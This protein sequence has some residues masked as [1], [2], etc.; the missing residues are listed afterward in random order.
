LPERPGLGHRVRRG[1]AHRSHF[2]PAQRRDHARVGRSNGVSWGGPRLETTGWARGREPG[3]PAEREGVANEVP[4]ATDGRVR[5]DHEVGPAE[6]LLHLLGA[7]L[8][9]VL[10]P[11]EPAEIV[12]VGGNGVSAACGPPGRAKLVARYHVVNWGSVAG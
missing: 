4:V 8:H 10:R 7:L 6:L 5:P 1:N 12:R 9:P 2:S 11:V 3:P